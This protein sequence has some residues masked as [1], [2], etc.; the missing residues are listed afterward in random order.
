MFTNQNFIDPKYFFRPKIFFDQNFL[1]PFS[2]FCDFSSITTKE[3]FFGKPEGDEDC[4]GRDSKE[5]SVILLH[6]NPMKENYL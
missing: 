6:K 1:G 4:E 5:K 2:K 3:R